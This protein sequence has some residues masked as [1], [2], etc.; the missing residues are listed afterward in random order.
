MS[1]NP[2]ETQIIAALETVLDPELGRS[3]VAAGMIKNVHIQ[4]GDVSFTLELTSPTCPLRN[5][6][7]QL[8]EE[9]CVACPA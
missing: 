5:R 2:S 8:A 4:G 3:L 9:A 1:R 7:R 6:L